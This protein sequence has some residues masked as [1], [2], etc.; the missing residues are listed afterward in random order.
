MTLRSRSTTWA[1]STSQ[2][3]RLPAV[4]WLGNASGGGRR[5][6]HGNAPSSPRSPAHRPLFARRPSFAWRVCCPRSG[7]RESAPKQIAP[8]GR[9]PSRAIRLVKYRVMDKKP[10]VAP[11][12]P[13]LE[14]NPGLD[15]TKPTLNAAFAAQL[16]KGTLS[17]LPAVAHLSHFRPRAPQI[18]R[19]RRIPRATTQTPH[20]PIR[21]NTQVQVAPQNPFATYSASVMNSPTRVPSLS[22][23]MAR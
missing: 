7:S 1:W 5:C 4:E 23:V 14:P 8:D 2:S 20:H 17:N 11:T 12:R 13:R 16:R 6:V 21:P 10:S 9:S 18:P 22:Q 15:A 19:K 3:C